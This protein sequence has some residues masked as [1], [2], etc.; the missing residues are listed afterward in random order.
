[1]TAV[2][3]TSFW[4]KGVSAV[5][6]A[7]VLMT[8]AASAQT[9]PAA[10]TAPA[11]AAKAPAT[12]VAPKSTVKDAVKAVTPVVC[13]GKDEASCKAEAATCSWIVPTKVDPK[14]GKADKAY[15]RRTAGV[16]KKAADAKKATTDALAKAGAAAKSAVTP[17]P[18]TT[19]PAKK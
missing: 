8:V 10:P 4:T 17:A 11:P 5:A 19:A 7:L 12:P 2:I 16:A 6:G 15:C 3:N 1:M 13:K 9:A 14:S 18:A